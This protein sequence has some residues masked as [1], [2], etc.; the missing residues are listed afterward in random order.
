MKYLLLL[1]L[2]ALGM[3]MIHS[4]CQ[5]TSTEVKAVIDGDT[6]KVDTLIIRIR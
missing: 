2:S 3:Y 6:V 5:K 4:V 1:L